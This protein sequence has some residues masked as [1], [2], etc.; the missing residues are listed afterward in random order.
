MPDNLTASEVEELKR[1]C[2]LPRTLETWGHYQMWSAINALPELLRT[3]EA[4]HRYRALSDAV[5]RAETAEREREVIRRERDA[6]RAEVADLKRERDDAKMEI[7]D[8]HAKFDAARDECERLREILGT[9]M[10][11]C[12][13]HGMDRAVEQVRNALKGTP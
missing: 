12:E 5:S 7:L 4:L 1:L 2:E 10:G 13:L 6:A 3:W 8:W 11:V 9:L